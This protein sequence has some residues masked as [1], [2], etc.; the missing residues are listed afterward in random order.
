MR[1]TLRYMAIIFHIY[2]FYGSGLKKWD[3]NL[4]VNKKLLIFATAY[5]K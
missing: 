5:K 3:K 4:A 1:Y 2:V